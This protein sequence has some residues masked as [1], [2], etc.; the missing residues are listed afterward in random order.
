MPRIFKCAAAVAL[1]VILTFCCGA[2]CLADEAQP[3]AAGDFGV[4][5][6]YAVIQHVQNNLT[7]EAYGK[8]VCDAA[9]S[10]ASG[11]IAEVTAELQQDN[12]GDWE[13][14]AKWTSSGSGHAVVYK[15]QYVSSGCGYR[16]KTT[17]TAYT[18]SH[19]FV[20]STTRYS[21]IVHY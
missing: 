20:E 15:Y 5:P 21:S 17:H 19:S 14:I 9:T 6:A 16:L 2:L 13:T 10:V 3:C 12:G 7:R 1:S 11:Y 18:S 4:A 8:M